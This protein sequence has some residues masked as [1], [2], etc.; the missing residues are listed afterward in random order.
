[1]SLLKKNTR[2]RKNDFKKHNFQSINQ[3]L[4]VHKKHNLQYISQDLKIILLDILYRLI[5]Y[6]LMGF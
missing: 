1:M 6:R 3:D 5:L 2:G 4:K